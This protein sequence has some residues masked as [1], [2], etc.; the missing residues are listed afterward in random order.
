MKTV[1]I[2]NVAQLRRKAGLKQSA[3][4]EK[5]GVSVAV[6]SKIE[7]GINIPPKARLEQLAYILKCNVGDI[8]TGITDQH[9]EVIKKLKDLTTIELSIIN[10]LLTIIIGKR[11]V[12]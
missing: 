2:N 3:V 4:A 6:V 1:K 7:R 11:Y 12:L 10:N 5:M 9:N 8:Q